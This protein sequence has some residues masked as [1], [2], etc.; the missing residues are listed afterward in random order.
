MIHALYFKHLCNGLPCSIFY[1]SLGCLGLSILLFNCSVLNIADFNAVDL[2]HIKYVFDVCFIDTVLAYSVKILIAKTENWGF[3][4]RGNCLWLEFNWW[5]DK[6]IK[7]FLK[8]RWKHKKIIFSCD[9]ICFLASLGTK[10]HD[11]REMFT[12]LYLQIGS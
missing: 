9:S 3:S 5:N 1:Y 4:F 2:P 8:N 7:E 6:G 10:S 11:T 12:N